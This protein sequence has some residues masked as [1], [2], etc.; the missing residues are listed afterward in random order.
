MPIYEYV[1]MHCESR[2][3][4]LVRNGEEPPCPNCASAQ[5]SRQVSVFARRG[6][7]PA[8]RF[9]QSSGGHAA[10]HHHHHGACSCARF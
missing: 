7:F 3:E 5:V 10:G 9:P 1:C 6:E 4:E 2:F 8:T